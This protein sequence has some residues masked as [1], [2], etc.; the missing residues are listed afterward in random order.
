M[1]SP[2][3]LTEALRQAALAV[4]G[5]EGERVFDDLAG[6]RAAAEIERQRSAASYRA[7]FDG[8]EACIFLHDCDSGAI[9]D[10][11][12]GAVMP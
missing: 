2:K 7:I 6:A 10:V 9:V 3:D 8:A 4:S 11:N 5:A 1:E 12:G